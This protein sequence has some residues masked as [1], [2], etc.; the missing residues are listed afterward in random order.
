MRSS[1]TVSA[2]VLVV[3]AAQAIAGTPERPDPYWNAKPLSF[4][5]AALAQSDA[6]VRE[7]A[8]NAVAQIAIVH[9]GRVAASAVG[10]LVHVLDSSEP[11]VRQAAAQALAE[12]GVPSHTAVPMLL[13]L[14]RD[15]EQPAVRRSATLAL[16]RIQPSAPAV[17]KEALRTLRADP[18]DGVRESAAILLSSDAA[19]A[20]QVTGELAAAS[21][22]DRDEGV[23][24]YSAVALGRGGDVDRALPVMLGTLRG[25]DATLRTEAAGLLPEIAPGRAEVVS[26]LI[27][28]LKDPE[29]DVRAAAAEG[30]G[31][32]GRSARS[33]VPPL[34]ALL[35]DPSEMVRDSVAA[36]ILRIRTD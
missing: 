23:R 19:T 17:V 12:I 22:T 20:R 21:R 4:W 3:S 30:L 1:L 24:F 29:P 18:H 34:G 7:G 6:R 35:R 26:A 15:D 9:G 16:G 27:E 14:V 10:P 8:A 31:C 25:S 36:A 28:S 13:K 33:A 2:A 32:L 5:V 11:G